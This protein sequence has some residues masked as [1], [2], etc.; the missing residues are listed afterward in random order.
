MLFKTMRRIF[1]VLFVCVAAGNAAQAADYPSPTEGDYT[2]RNFKFGSGETLPELKIH[3][4]TLGKIEKDA[5]GKVTNAVLIMHGTTGS[6]AQ[7]IRPEFAGELF[8]KDQPLDVT[9]FFIVLPDGIGHGKSSKPSDGMH[10]KF[11]RYGYLDMVDAQY[12][13]LTDG[14]G[15]NH[16]RL[17]MGTSMGGMHS[18][19]WGETHPDFMDAL[20]PLAGLPAQISG[21]NRGW[22]RM[23]IDAIR[24]DPAWNGGEY[25]TQPPSLRTA[26]EMLWFMSSNPVL[27][28]KEAPTLA[29]TDEVLDKF[30]DQIVKMDDANDVLYA[31]EASHDYDPGPNLEKIRAPLLAINSADDLINPPEL[32]I[33]E[34]EIKRVPHGRAIVI[35]FSDQTRGHGSH[36]VAALWKDE[37][38]K[39]LQETEKN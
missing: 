4:R 1:A 13:L 21:R 17:V 14:L 7:F 6:G 3:Y 31:L 27:R 38:V 26:A 8:G 11:P 24:N 25:K 19:L 9:K 35:P 39:L 16:A 15:V 36:T 33:L 29:K 37:L 20:M 23:I 10:A 28:Q 18:W 22:R 12:R 5:N 32:G 30:V 34:R 2:I